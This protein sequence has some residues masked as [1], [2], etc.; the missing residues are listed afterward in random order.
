MNVGS[1]SGL[2]TRGKKGLKTIEGREASLV[3]WWVL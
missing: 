1:H 3:D 2:P